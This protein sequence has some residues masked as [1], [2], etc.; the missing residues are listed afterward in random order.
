MSGVNRLP[1]ERY[2]CPRCD[3][4]FEDEEVRDTWKC[5]KCSGYIS[6]Y[7]EDVETDT[8][9]VLIRKQA[10]E[11]QKGDLVHLPGMLTKEPYLVLGISQQNNGKLCIGLKQYGQYKVLADEP[12]NCRIGAWPSKNA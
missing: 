6:V 8:R 9:I 1:S 5:P 12:V 7:A 2:E 3:E 11:V 4:A 10:S